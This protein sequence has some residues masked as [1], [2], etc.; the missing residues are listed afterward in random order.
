MKNNFG[1]KEHHDKEL[2]KTGMRLNEQITNEAIE[3]KD[4][5]GKK[6]IADT[7]KEVGTISGIY[8]DPV[9]FSVAGIDIQRGFFSSNRFIR[10]EFIDQVG[11]NGI[12]LNT[13]PPEEFKGAKVY[14]IDA[15]KVG[16]VKEVHTK[17]DTNT[18][19]SLTIDRG[20]GKD[21]LMVTRNEIHWV[22]DRVVIDHKVD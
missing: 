2:D 13:T 11:H 18:I 12:F 8:L 7:G 1:S 4:L 17:G 21:D 14:D 10:R 19:D 6:V 15:K 3:A 20:T 5:L 16:H 22:G 9:T